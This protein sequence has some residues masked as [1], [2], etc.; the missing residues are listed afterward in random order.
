[1]AVPLQRL[2]DPPLRRLST[3]RIVDS[4]AEITRYRDRELIERSLMA[5]LSELF[6]E[7]EF[8]LYRVI[9]GA[10]A[11]ELGLQVYARE[12][13]VVPAPHPHQ[14]QVPTP[15]LEVIS[16]AI[17]NKDVVE[18]RDPDGGPLTLVYP[19]YD[20]HD[21]ICALMV[22]KAQYSCFESQ[23]L[24]YGLL[25]IYANYYALLE[26]SHRDKLTNLLNRETLEVEIARR[27][28]EYQRAHHRHNRRREESNWRNWL[29][30]ID[31][32]HFKSINDEWGHLYG[33]EV[34]IL[35]AR[36]LES[37]FRE[38][39]LIFRYGGEEFVAL[40]RAPEL[41]DAQAACERVRT[42]VAGHTFPGVG[43]VTVSIGV[44]EVRDQ[45]SPAA[46]LAQADQALYYAKQHG[47]NCTHFY[48]LLR[49]AGV[50]NEAS[51]HQQGSVDFF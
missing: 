20:K 2:T 7:E 42:T 34:L 47:R 23:R 18:H 26:E 9:A 6:P 14:S 36:L 24:T 38:E 43:Q 15:L 48:A 12:G 44:V 39:D 25:R 45:D 40:F 3:L 21:E 51:Q 35:L 10:D 50:L 22:E 16:A 41:E 17:D 5:T 4:L 19:I 46:A 8:W 49:A 33:D 13:L 31:A 37:T 1:M 32:D 28:I 30:L 29:A 27:I 11:V